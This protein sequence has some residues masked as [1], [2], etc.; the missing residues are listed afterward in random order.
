LVEQCPFKAYSAFLGYLRI[1]AHEFD[2]IPRY[3]SLLAMLK[4][5][6]V[7]LRLVAISCKD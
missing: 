4:I 1:S 6:H 3:D 5:A 2:N 7:R